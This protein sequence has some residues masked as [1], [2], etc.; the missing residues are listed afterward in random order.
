MFKHHAAQED[1][2]VDLDAAE[3]WRLIGEAAREAIAQAGAQPSDIVAVS[4][5]GMRHGSVIVDKAGNVLLATPT[6][7]ARGAMQGLTLAGDRGSEFNQKT[8]HWPA[9]LFT[10]SRLLWAAECAPEI[11]QKADAVLSL[12]DWLAWRISGEMAAEPSTSSESGL[13]EVAT[14]KW[15]DDLIESLSLPRRLFPKVATAGTRI[16]TASK[17]A[18]EH[19]GIA[20]GTPVVVGGGDT[21]CGLLGAGAVESGHL[22][23]IAGTTMPIQLVLDRPIVDGEGRVWT[24]HHVIPGRWVLESNGG[25]SGDAL[26]WLAGILY[27]GMKSPS[28]A[29]SIEAADSSIG[30]E[31]IFSTLGAEIFCA[32]RMR[33]PVGHLTLST[34][35]VSD[36]P[37]RRRHIARSILEGIAYAARANIDLLEEVAGPHKIAT[38]QIRL[39]GGMSKSACFAQ[40]A[41]NV[42]GRSVEVPAT[43]EVSA[44]GA[45]I[46]AGVGAGIYKDLRDGASRAAKLA[47]T[48]SA[49]RAAH[50]TYEG[51][52]GK[53]I[54]VRRV[55]AEADE[56]A[57]GYA[58]E[59]I[60]AAQS[61]AREVENE[62]RAKNKGGAGAFRP[63]ILVTASMDEHGLAALGRVGD[64]EYKSF[65]EHLQLLAGDDLVDA[66]KGVSVF[67]TEV[68]AVDAEVLAKADDLRV[69]ASCRGNAVNLDID[70][71]SAHGI[72]VLTTPGRNADAVAD[73]T[74]AFMLM[75]A[76]KLPSATQF[77]HEPGEAGDMGR[78]GRAFEQLQGRE[79]WRKTIGIVGFGAVG[80]RV[81]QRVAPFGVHIAVYDP[82]LS[83]E[84]ALLAGV[85]HMSLE[86][87]LAESDIVTLHAAVTD[88]SRALIGAAE[89]AKMKPGAYL[90][91]TARSALVDENALI[92]ALNSG[93]IAGAALDVFAVEP[94]APDHPLLLLPNVIATPHVGGNTVEVSSHQGAIVAA[95]IERLLKGDRPAEVANPQTLEA[96]S[97][98]GARVKP[99]AATLAELRKKSVSVTDIS[100]EASS[101]KS[102]PKQVE[103]AHHVSRPTADTARPPIAYAPPGNEPAAKS[104]LLAG[105]KNAILGK[106]PET[107][108]GSGNHPPAATV[109]LAPVRAQMEK[110]LQSFGKKL[111]S[112][113]KLLS[114]SEG[115][116]VTVRYDLSDLGLAFYTS[117]DNGAVRTGV[118]APP[119]KP[120]VTL[121]MKA[122]V[123]DR[124]FTGKESGPKAAMSGK[125]SFTGD[126][127]K[128]MSLQ[129]I[130]K[131]LNRVY[132]NARSE[133]VDI[134]ALLAQSAQAS[135]P[136][137]GGKP[138][139]ASASHAGAASHAAP[140]SG[141]IEVGDIRDEVVRAVEELYA[142]GLITSTGGNV[143][144]RI[145]GAN[146]AWITPNSSAKGALR[147]D[148]LVRVDLD[149]NAVD[150]TPYAPSSE[151]MIHCAI[152]RQNPQVGAVIHSHAPKAT[153]LALADLPF[154]PISTEAAFIGE[155]PRVPFIMPGTGE[156]ADAVAKAVMGAPAALMQNHG[157]I[158]AGSDLKRGIDMTMVIESTAEKILDC[159]SVGKVPPV[160]PPDLVTA[161]RSLDEMLA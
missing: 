8:G 73:L 43:S 103:A 52:F 161:L 147:P 26:D 14:A 7:D 56:L 136:V 141:R 41:S 32:S 95:D 122:D 17:Q 154:L 67:I 62:K 119:D 81:A 36:D 145:P 64:V 79:L 23:I 113:D 71:C 13:F 33:L 57:E 126:T 137:A 59:A 149:G 155:L 124:L 10:S 92:A 94:P 116:Q 160:L 120:Q 112:D 132:T 151:R 127:V 16:G 15:A 91:N 34:M 117:F 143:S 38:S 51:L 140:A 159:Y 70:A 123:L 82:F 75:M 28:A 105:L 40:L 29:M 133:V 93:H 80:R 153:T 65:R 121:K 5:T 88:E 27:P 24:S 66:L 97:W 96:F 3:V 104:G 47:K 19:L 148:M 30:A 157:L 39:G 146:Q 60:T 102:A 50:E 135:N 58:I 152:Y 37:S 86:Q 76:R 87:L 18:A 139:A 150:D 12:S 45:A 83:A 107:Q 134:D 128:A 111:S 108:N 63:R 114:F 6:R 77:L 35:M 53:W 44:L 49:D 99:S 21:Q 72:P 125:L 100:K 61:R 22:A 48:Y 110:L 1:W 74:V 131:D 54:E 156:L 115:R 106:R 85:E 55:R 2:G 138:A 42:L 89:I 78:M 84:K 31:G 20:A 130:Q 4:T 46:C 69:V 158:V 118:G 98:T 101:T 11:L 109:D 90:V 9:P 25:S 142:H 129:R 68:D 144:V